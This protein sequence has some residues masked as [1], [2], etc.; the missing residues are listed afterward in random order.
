MKPLTKQTVKTAS[1]F[2]TIGLLIGLLI[3]AFIAYGQS[4]SSTFTISSGVY[5]GA[6]SYTIWVEG[7]EYFVKDANGLI[8][9]SGANFTTLS[10]SCVMALPLDGGKIVF[11]VGAYAGHIVI[12]RSNIILEGE[13]GV[14]NVPVPN[15]DVGNAPTSLSG[16]VITPEEGYDAFHISGANRTGIQIRNF[17][18]WFKTANTG[19]AI[20]T[21]DDTK[22]HLKFALFENIQVLDVDKDSYA[23]S[24]T[25]F[26]H[27]TV[28]HIHSYGGCLL[29]IYCS[30]PNFYQGDSHFSDMMAHVDVD[31]A[32]I[33]P[34]SGPFPIYI[35]GIFMTS[36]RNQ[37]LTFDNIELNVAGAQSDPDYYST[38]VYFL[39]NG[40][41]NCFHS[42]GAGNGYGTMII[43]VGGCT[44]VQFNAPFFWTMNGVRVN[45]GYV[46]NGVNWYGG[47]VHGDVF[48]DNE[49]DI[50][51]GTWILGDVVTASKA[52][53]K[54][55]IGNSGISTLTS[56]QTSVTV[57]ATFIGPNNYVLLTIID[58][59]TIAAGEALKVSTINVSPTNTFDV[60]CIDE[61][62]ASVSISFY[63]Q[64]C[65]VP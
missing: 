49:T 41:F 11:R 64:I 31:L 2:V 51:Y 21:D 23:I 63:W 13:G 25:N 9:Y 34:D 30:M 5:P 10:A 57:P 54:N 44:N 7:S 6:P 27:V 28:R 58:A 4:P 62:T 55:L 48:D 36:S 8:A 18:V 61:G 47:S 15:S 42:E 38:I 17:G 12:N 16:T 1:K 40:I 50:W 29:K 20:S 56:G 59:D 43:N 22:F 52:D 24:L 65:H 35:S 37:G 39:T 45:S 33:D 19:D 32:P 53:F 14:G 26:L 60:Q 3:G 46:C